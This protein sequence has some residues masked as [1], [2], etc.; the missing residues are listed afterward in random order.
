VGSAAG[1]ASAPASAGYKGANPLGTDREVLLWDEMAAELRVLV[2]TPDFPPARGGIQVVADRLVCHARRSRMRVVTLGAAQAELFD[3]G[4]RLDVRRAPFSGRRHHRSAILGL[5]GFALR[6]AL[7]FHPEAVLSVHIVLSPAAW[8]IRRAIG[9]PIVQYLH[10]D[11]IRARPGLT[12]F[13]VRHASAVVAVSEHTRELALAAGADPSR[14]HRIPNGVDLPAASKVARAA[15][16]TVLTVARLRERYKGHDVLVRAMPLIRARV[17]D[18]QWV[19]VGDG[20]LRPELERL[21]ADRGLDGH[22]CFVGEISD[23]ERDAWLDRAHVF[24]MPARVPHGGVGGEGFGIVYLEAGA[25]GLPVVAGNVGG[26]LDAVVDGETGLL[27]DPSD[28]IA[29]A[30]AI[31]DLLLDPER[32]AALG[33]AGAARASRFTWPSIAGRVEELLHHVPSTAKGRARST[34]GGP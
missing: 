16:P 29:V 27:A 17:P 26:A 19:V 7:R 3:R 32:A 4:K 14:L 18:A 6:E 2:L 34:L 30:G 25:H 8:M 24:A 10:A 28:H 33:R 22:V 15:R 5:N 1:R 23:A 20:P 11:E 21:A 13:A 9:A 12:G 31:A